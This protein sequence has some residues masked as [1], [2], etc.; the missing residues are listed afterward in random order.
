MPVDIEVDGKLVGRARLGLPRLDVAGALG[1]PSLVFA[2]WECLLD[3]HAIAAGRRSLRIEAVAHARSGAR[4]SIGNATITIDD[5][6]P[7]RAPRDLAEDHRRGELRRRLELL[8][9]RQPAPP[10]RTDGRLK[11]LAVIHNLDRGGSQLILLERL[12]KLIAEGTAEAVV[13]SPSDGALC[14][15]FESIG[16]PCHV[17]GSLIQPNAILYEGKIAE[18]AMWCRPQGFDVVLAST[19]AA[20]PGIDLAERLG[21][22][23]LWLIYE[24]P[25]SP[26]HLS[27]FVALNWPAYA[28]GQTNEALRRCPLIVFDSDSCRRE[29]LERAPP[30]RLLTIPGAIDIAAIERFRAAFDR[31]S[32]RRA[33]G[34]PKGARLVLGLGLIVALKGTPL[35]VQAFANLAAEQP[36]LHLALVGS[37]RNPVSEAVEQFVAARGLRDRVFI[38]PMGAEAYRWLGMADLLVCASDRESMPRTVLEGMAFEVP[39]LATTVGDIP[40]VIADGVSGWLIAPSDPV[41]LEAAI[42]RALAA[43]HE[44]RSAMTA[45]AAR[46]VREHR[47]ARLAGERF[48]A[49]LHSV[50][51]PV[52]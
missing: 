29:Y 36:D 52:S 6:V 51:M 21:L 18:L 26:R 38:E 40:S 28:I 14:H 31:A 49:A 8:L 4:V 22:P 2:G 24:Q 19:I 9:D 30:E 5:G 50:L 42:R 35:L 3:F 47:D 32:A 45:A 13:V 16:I 1:D 41:T 37:R 7:P 48:A 23:S 20:S 43:S 10:R 12:R 11:I 46:I 44:E 15:D 39:V 27:P 33:C 25:A 34:L 17:T